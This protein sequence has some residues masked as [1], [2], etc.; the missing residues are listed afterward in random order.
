MKNKPLLSISLMTPGKK[1]TME[2]CL[3]AMDHLRKTIPCEVV[4]V[5]TGCDEEHR[6]IVD[7]YADKVVEFEWC[8]DFSKARNVGVKQCTG[9]W[10]MFIDD[11]EV[12]KDTAP[13]E[14]F[15]L[16]GEYKK[17]H[18]AKVRLRDYVDWEESAYVDCYLIRMIKM[19]P[20]TRFANKIHEGLA[21]MN[22]NCTVVEAVLGHYGYIYDTP[23]ERWEHSF[24][25][26]EVLEKE[27]AADPENFHY[28]Q[29]L[30][31]EYRA[32]DERSK[33]EN[34]CKRYYQKTLEAKDYSVKI[35]GG[36]FLG[37]WCHALMSQCRYQETIEIVREGEAN[38]YV[39]ELAS[40]I[41]Y[42][43]GCISALRIGDYETCIA[44][45]R[46]YIRNYEEFVDNMDLWSSV[47]FVETAFEDQCCLL[48]M[49]T[50][51]LAS[52]EAYDNKGVEF[53]TSKVNWDYENALIH[54]DMPKT[55][56][57]VVDS[58]VKL[59]ALSTLIA[60]ILK[61]DKRAMVLLKELYQQELIDKTF[62]DKIAPYF[63]ESESTHYYAI[64][65]QILAADKN[66]ESKDYMGQLV[67][68]LFASA[69]DIFNFDDEV[70]AI[71]EKYGINLELL[72]LNKPFA[73][74]ARGIRQMMKGATAEQLEKYGHLVNGIRTG[75]DIRYT[76]FDMMYNYRMFLLDTTYEQRMR[77]L[78]SYVF[79][80][81]KYYP[82]VFS[83]EALDNRILL[84]EGASIYVQLSEFLQWEEQKDYKQ[85]LATIKS[86]FGYNHQLDNALR[87]FSH[88]YGEHIDAN[89]QIA[90]EEMLQ[91]GEQIKKQ[92][93]LMIEAGQTKEAYQVLTQMAT[94]LPQ[95]QEIKDLI[96]LTGEK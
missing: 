88:Q 10:F 37:A 70:Y 89:T 67:R 41:L 38:G 14:Q 96:I 8:N 36:I 77:Y 17:W 7:K 52:I 29:Q 73:G 64:T 39:N 32:I 9:E 15:F 78:K 19:E 50:A 28:A 20:E 27:L 48:T 26:V 62:R 84:S 18:E 83:K 60:V 21:T 44:Y 75:E 85:A 69:D 42:S 81:E 61:N 2:A 35:R 90:S 65:L 86:T 3:R 30:T 82:T 66:N 24:R 25:N 58:G 1:R 12:F 94:Y 49:Q 74:F 71:I 76:F 34:L 4:V 72:I 51:L 16:S 5:D 53:F 55:I 91:L 22:G 43:F 45:G 6:A 92:A 54:E 47:F 46:K 40:T 95:D 57:K 93:K 11:D 79:Y 13:L 33:L 31:V 59:P 63:I 68:K 87:S 80:G 56:I 23:Q